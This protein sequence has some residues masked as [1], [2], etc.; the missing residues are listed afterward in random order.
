MKISKNQKKEKEKIRRLRYM[1]NN[2]KKGLVYV[3][4]K[5]WVSKDKKEEFIASLKKFLEKHL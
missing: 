5:F 1:E 2:S 4:K 3:C